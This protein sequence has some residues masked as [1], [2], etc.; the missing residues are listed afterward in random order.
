MHADELTQLRRVAEGVDGV[1]CAL[2]DDEVGTVAGDH[3]PDLDVEIIEG[4]VESRQYA[5][6]DD[7][8]CR[9]GV[10]D[11]GLQLRIAAD[12]AVVLSG[13]VPWRTEGAVLRGGQADGR[14]PP[15][16]LR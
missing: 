16:A 5:R 7:Q 10:S 6:R 2:I 4:H 14:R 15:A 8:T 13:G 3:V 9:I 1:E 12:L 11:L